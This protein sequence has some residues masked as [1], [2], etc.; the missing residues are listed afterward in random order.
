ML[1]QPVTRLGAQGRRRE[2]VEAGLGH[3]AKEKTQLEDNQ[4]VDK[5]SD[6]PN[7]KIARVPRCRPRE[8]CFAGL[9]M[10]RRRH[11]VSDETAV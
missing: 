7:A 5:W 10:L 9:V 11:T 1:G 3:K 4:A 8:C 6:V 2:E